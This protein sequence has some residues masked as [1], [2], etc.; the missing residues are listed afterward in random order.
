MYRSPIRVD[1]LT[2][3]ICQEQWMVLNPMDEEEYIDEEQDTLDPATSRFQEKV[4]LDISPPR[5]QLQHE[6]IIEKIDAE[7]VKHTKNDDE[8]EEEDYVSNAGDRSTTTR[9]ELAFSE[10]DLD[11]IL[12]Q[13]PARKTTKVP[14]HSQTDDV[15]VSTEEEQQ[16]KETS[17]MQWVLSFLNNHPKETEV[18]TPKEESDLITSDSKYHFFLQE[19]NHVEQFYHDPKTMKA[20]SPSVRSPH[21]SNILDQEAED[22]QIRSSS[23]HFQRHVEEKEEGSDLMTI[24]ANMTKTLAQFEILQKKHEQLAKHEAKIQQQPQYQQQDQEQEQ[25]KKKTKASADSDESATNKEDAHDEDE[26]ED[27]DDW[28]STTRDAIKRGIIKPKHQ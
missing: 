28:H 3:S 26:D 8:E 13:L 15:A 18:V 5:I 7:V 19:L 17:E 2:E 10:E 1:F 23:R 12:S 21:R 16:D 9:L 20:L 6:K 27:D 11:L 24:N 14:Y 4:N 22:V 25:Q